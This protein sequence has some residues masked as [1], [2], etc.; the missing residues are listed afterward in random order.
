MASR[1]VTYYELKHRPNSTYPLVKTLLRGHLRSPAFLPH[2]EKCGELH[3]TGCSEDNLTLIPPFRGWIV[4][5]EKWESFTID[6]KVLL[7][8]D[9][10]IPY[11]PPTPIGD[12]ISVTATAGGST[13]SETPGTPPLPALMVATPTTISTPVETVIETPA[14]TIV[15]PSISSPPAPAPHP[16]AMRY[17]DIVIHGKHLEGTDDKHS[18]APTATYEVT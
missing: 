7:D 15:Q 4:S 1:E 5:G 8:P 12:D 3:S 17:A 18:S 9:V 6:G 11:V 10:F 14:Q 2:F 16:A 13:P